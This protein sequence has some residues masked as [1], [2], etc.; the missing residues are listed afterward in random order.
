[1]EN[2]EFKN[3]N[4][5]NVSTNISNN[6]QVALPN[7]TGVLVLGIISVSIFWCYGLFSVVLGIIALV[8]SKKAGALYNENPKNYTESSYKNMKAGRICAII[9]LS[10][11]ALFIILYAL[12][13][14]A[15]M[16]GNMPFYF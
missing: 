14:S 12:I 6:K 5:Q 2:T 11:G 16:L 4:S 15:A 7:A 1:M 13:F 10:C 9:G 3:E 8:L